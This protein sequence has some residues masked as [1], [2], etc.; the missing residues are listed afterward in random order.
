[1]RRRVAALV[2]LLALVAAVIWALTAVARSG[3]TSEETSPETSIPDTL[4]TTPTEPV[5]G[6]STSATSETAATETK[7]SGKPSTSSEASESPDD[8]KLA[9][10]T[11]CELNDLRLTLRANKTDF[12]LDDAEDQPDFTVQVHN[13]TGGD[14]TID[15]NEHR[16]RFEVYQIGREGFQPMW[17]DTDCYEP[18]INGDQTFKAGDSRNFNAAWSRLASAPGQCSDRQQVAP[19][20]YVATASL[21]DNTSEGITFNLR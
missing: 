20:A 18:V 19:G 21:G 3:S 15:A 2:I 6:E 14:C 9:A 10:K 4:V 13:P 17:S 5:P 7:D 12:A 1:M 16:L 8:K 11:T